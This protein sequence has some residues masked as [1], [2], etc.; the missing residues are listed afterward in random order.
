MTIHRLDNL[1]L[2]LLTVITIVMIP[3][4]YSV[5]IPTLEQFRAFARCPNG[6]PERVNKLFLMKDCHDVRMAFTEAQVE[7]AKR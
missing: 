4:Y 1:A 7:I 6:T 3:V 5:F 2:W